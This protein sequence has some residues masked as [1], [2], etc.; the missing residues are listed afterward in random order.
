MQSKIKIKTKKQGVYKVC[1]Y[2]WKNMSLGDTLF[3]NIYQ[4]SRPQDV[5]WVAGI[6]LESAI[7]LQ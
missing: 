4:G 6:R 3:F 5:Y 2:S 7:G 1:V